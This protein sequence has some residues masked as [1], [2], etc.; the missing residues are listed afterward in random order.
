MDILIYVLYFYACILIKKEGGSKFGLPIKFIGIFG[1]YLLNIYRDGRNQ[2]SK[3]GLI[4]ML[5]YDLFFIAQGV[6]DGIFS[7]EMQ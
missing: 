1:S 7:K 2:E 6:I 5:N 4:S 3:Y